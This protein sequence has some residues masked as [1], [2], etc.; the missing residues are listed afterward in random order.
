MAEGSRTPS[1]QPA[2]VDKI[3]SHLAGDPRLRLPGSLTQTSVGTDADAGR[4]RLDYL[5]ALLSKDP[6]VFLERHGELLPASELSLFESLRDDYEVNF[7]LRQLEQQLELM[8][9]HLSAQTK[10]RRLAHLNRLIDEGTFFEDGAMRSRA[11]LLHHQY[12]G[13]YRWQEDLAAKAASGV[14][15]TDRGGHPLSDSVMARLE[16]AQ[17]Q[18]RLDQ[19]QAAQD[20][21]EQESSEEGDWPEDRRAEMQQSP[22]DTNLRYSHGSQPHLEGDASED[23]GDITLERAGFAR[24]SGSKG[25]SNNASTAPPGGFAGVSQA[26]A[27]SL[28]DPEGPRGQAR[29]AALLLAHAGREASDSDADHSDEGDDLPRPSAPPFIHIPVEEQVQL[30]ADFLALM[31]QRFLSGE[32]EDVDYRIIDADQS[33]DDDLAGQIGQDAEDAYF[34]AD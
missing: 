12:V 6:G 8:A 20:Q 31:H 32:E 21:I 5:S 28:K 23:C 24:S 17:T 33:L 13:Q 16:E 29:T 14:I 3:A 15:P 1:L 18:R 34:D 25:T 9:D 11:P 30:Q 27:A 26:A 7:Y 22:A 2:A 19:Q 10:N 4:A